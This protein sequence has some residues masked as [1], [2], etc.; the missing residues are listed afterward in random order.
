[1]EWEESN[2]PKMELLN[3]SAKHRQELLEEVNIISD[4]AERII[5]NALIIGGTLAVAYFVVRQFAFSRPKK[6]K[7]G[8]LKI[9]APAADTRAE[10]EEEEAPAGSGVIAQIGTALASQAAVLLLDLAKEKLTEYIQ[11]QMVKK[12]DENER[13]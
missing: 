3:K 2:N 11:G 5:T 10:D 4:Q 1:M 13:S 12:V 6:K 9:S 8:R 7:S